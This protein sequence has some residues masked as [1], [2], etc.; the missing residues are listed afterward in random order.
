MGGAVPQVGTGPRE[1]DCCGRE[2]VNRQDESTANAVG[3]LLQL[4]KKSRTF[5][6]NTEALFRPEQ[7]FRKDLFPPFEIV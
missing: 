4:T 5:Y 1:Q 6:K 2:R 7:G 3:F